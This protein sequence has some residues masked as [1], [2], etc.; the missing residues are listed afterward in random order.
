MN[1][2]IIT[3]SD[4]SK[5]E[6]KTKLY[7][8]EKIIEFLKFIGEWSNDANLAELKENIDSVGCNYQN[9]REGN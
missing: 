7:D 9:L 1:L 3:F 8:T 6:V 4:G 5:K 2:A